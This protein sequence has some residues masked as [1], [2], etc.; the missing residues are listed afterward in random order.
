MADI[1]CKWRKIAHQLETM[2]HRRKVIDPSVL[3]KLKDFYILEYGMLLVS[4][5]AS[6][7]AFSSQNG[8][9]W[10]RIKGKHQNSP[11]AHYKK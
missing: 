9:S 11:M 10:L 4:V 8:Q 1:C 3:P 6:K 2:P 7:L 5:A